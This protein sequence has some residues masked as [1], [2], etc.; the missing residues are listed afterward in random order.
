LFNLEASQLFQFSPEQHFL[1][2]TRD[3]SPEDARDKVL[4]YAALNA[5]AALAY[6]AL[7]N[8]TMT[9][10]SFLNALRLTLKATAQF[11][12]EAWPAYAP[13]VPDLLEALKDA[14]LDPDTEEL[15]RASRAKR[16][17]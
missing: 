15:L 6:Q 17:D 5:E 10:N 14:P 1:M 7:G 12:T 8:A 3:E 9:R 4:L 13:R 11:P 2:L 16:P